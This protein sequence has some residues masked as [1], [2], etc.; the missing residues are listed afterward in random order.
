MPHPES[1]EHEP[2][3][4]DPEQHIGGLDDEDGEDAILGGEADVHI[5]SQAEKKTFWWRNALINA[6]FILAW[7]NTLNFTFLPRPLNNSTQVPFC[8]SAFRV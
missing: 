8:D 2:I 1:S 3:F 4:S 5:A 6:L 7:Y